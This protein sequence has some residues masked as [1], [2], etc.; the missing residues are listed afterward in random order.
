VDGRPC[1]HLDIAGP[2]WSDSENSTR[3]AGGTGCFVRT[4]LRLLESPNDACS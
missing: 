3:D 2:S 4:L 1:V